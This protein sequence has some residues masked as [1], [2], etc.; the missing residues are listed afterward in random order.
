MLFPAALRLSCHSLFMAS[1]PSC[2]ASE[3]PVVAV[4]TACFVDGACHKSARMAMPSGNEMVNDVDKN[5]N[6]GHTASM[7]DFY[8]A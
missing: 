3:E 1:P 4:P 8:I 2:T 6:F 5:I 7:N